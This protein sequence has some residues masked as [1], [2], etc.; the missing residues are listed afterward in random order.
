MRRS[1]LSM[2]R[3]HFPT[4]WPV[5]DTALDVMKCIKN[6]RIV[7]WT[8]RRPG[9]LHALPK[10]SSF[11][12]WKIWRKYHGVCCWQKWCIASGF[13]ERR[14]MMKMR[15]KETYLVE[16]IY[17]DVYCATSVLTDITLRDLLLEWLQGGLPMPWAAMARW[18]K[19]LW[20]VGDTWQRRLVT[21]GWG[22]NIR[23]YQYGQ[24]WTVKTLNQ[25]FTSLCKP[26]TIL[27]SSF[28]SK[29]VYLTQV[30]LVLGG[31]EEA[32]VPWGWNFWWL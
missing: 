12:W 18:W 28:P 9:T 21:N 31:F 5:N 19:M 7:F 3:C 22:K 14:K 6:S 15:P 24:I 30:A 27:L 1:G 2:T 10:H 8:I 23:I 17:C 13:N 4:S 32:T 20:D 29:N 11:R 16:W 26:T 25:M